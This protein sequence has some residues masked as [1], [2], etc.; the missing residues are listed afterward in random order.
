MRA[1][2]LTPWE[3]APRGLWLS[4][5]MCEKEERRDLVP[6]PSGRSRATPTAGESR[7]GFGPGGVPKGL[8]LLPGK[9][10][11]GRLRSQ[12]SWW[13]AMGAT[14]QL[15]LCRRRLPAPANSGVGAFPGAKGLCGPGGRVDHDGDSWPQARTGPADSASITDRLSDVEA[16]APM[17]AGELCPQL[18]L[19][20]RPGPV[21]AA[22]LG[23]E[24]AFVVVVEV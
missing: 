5:S 1:G 18:L 15:L 17:V 16:L 6:E 4:I 21:H 9:A 8:S 23:A 3:V 13:P 2:K 12:T 22:A 20:S 19:E 11:S 10:A 7:C 24:V 14:L